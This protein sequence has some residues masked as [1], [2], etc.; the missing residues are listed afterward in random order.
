MELALELGCGDRPAEGF[1]HHDR[2]RHSPHVDLAFDLRYRPW[3]V[4]W[5]TRHETGDWRYGRLE[6]FGADQVRDWRARARH[7]QNERD[8]YGTIALG[9]GLVRPLAFLNRLRAIDVFEHV[10]ADIP[11][12]LDECWD[13]LLV[14]GQLELRLPSYWNPN[15]FRDPTHV[16][17]GIHPDTLLYWDPRSELQRRF[18]AIYF[19]ES[20]RW[21]HVEEVKVEDNDLHVWMTKLAGGPS[22]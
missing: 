4:A 8:P 15:T 22:S 16:L 10:S 20:N 21:W 6:T 18:G 12:W 11:T 2:V 5:V 17:R 7:A 19:A 14:G 9:G 13:L 1:I 3:P